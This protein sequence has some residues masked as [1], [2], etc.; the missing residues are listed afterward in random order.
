MLRLP[1]STGLSLIELMVTL[2]LFAILLGLGVPSFSTWLQ[3]TRIRGTAE[4][5]MTG[6]QYAKSEATARNALVRFQLTSSVGADCIISNS[7]TS[8]VIDLVDPASEDDS[9]AG[10][11]DAAPSDQVQPAILQKK[12]AQDGSGSSVVEASDSS[13]TFNGLGRLVPLPARAISLV[14]SSRNGSC[15][16]VGGDLSCLRILVSPGGQVRMCNPSYPA[17]DPQ[18]C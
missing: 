9:V 10:Q 16:E 18:A 15:A 4:A 2:S 6:L 12:S 13:M 5:L 14:V 17:G 3:N 8:W 11:C 1:D 7:G